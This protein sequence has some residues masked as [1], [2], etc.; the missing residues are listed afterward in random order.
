M[1]IAVCSRIASMLFAASIA[2][3]AAAATVTTGELAR[4]EGLRSYL[5]A[6]PDKPA[7]GKLPLVIMFHGHGSSAAMLFG[8]DKI[9][10]PAA[11]WLTLADREQLLYI[12]PDGWRG[13]DHKRGWNDCRADATTNPATDDIALLG[14]LIDKAVASHNADPRRI[15]VIGVSNGGGMAYRAAIELPARIAA[16]SVLSA[17]MPIESGCAAPTHA[18]PML[19]THGTDDTI[20]PYAGGKVSHWMLS[21]RGSGISAEDSVRIWR[22][23]AQLPA[24]PRVTAYPHQEASGASSAE[25]FAWGERPEQ[26]QVAFIKVT[27]GGH[28]TPSMSVRYPW[29][30]TSLVGKQNADLEFVEE[31]WSFF[32]D[33]RLAPPTK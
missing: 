25:R 11:L 15:Y 20:T 13:S 8:R 19:I 18:M 14:A 5:L 24:T 29:L 32:K 21:G 7:L 23:L 1:K 30:V 28:S 26:L 22:E 4:P 31:A 3:S 33:K 12:A 6:Q 16:V 2:G 27:K 10:D 9:K 17:L